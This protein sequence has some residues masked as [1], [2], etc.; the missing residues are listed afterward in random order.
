MHESVAQSHT[1]VMFSCVTVYTT[2]G[3]YLQSVSYIDNRGFS[4]VETI[5]AGPI[6]YQFLVVTDPLNSAC[7]FMFYVK[8]SG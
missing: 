7:Y 3:L 5:P 8:K 4:G 1:V 6:G 2:G